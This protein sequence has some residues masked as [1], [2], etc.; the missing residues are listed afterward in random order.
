MVI[1]FV[2]QTLWLAL[3]IN[4][5]SPF[6]YS[7]TFST[8]IP[9][10]LIIAFVAFIILIVAVPLAIVFMWGGLNMGGRR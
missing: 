10:V 4:N 8:Y 2:A 9:T 7:T 1:F 3:P 5:S 6:F